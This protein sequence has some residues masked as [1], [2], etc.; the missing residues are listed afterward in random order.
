[1]VRNHHNDEERLNTSEP[2]TSASISGSSKDG[3]RHDDRELLERAR[4]GDQSAF[5]ELVERY[6]QKAYGVAFGFCRNREDALDRVQEAFVKAY[7]NITRFEGSSSFYTWFYRILVNVCID[8]IRKE[9]KRK[10]DVGY[11]DGYEHDDKDGAFV[12]TTG[13]IGNA[14]PVKA[15]AN[16]ELGE[17]IQEAM[18]KLSESHR[19]IL[20]LREVEGLSYEELS[21]VLGVPRGTVMSRL[22]HARGKLKALLAGYVRS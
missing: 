6:Q 19:E 17:K 18:G 10:G 14:N 5:R 7:R 16:Q 2:N 21:E 15:L 22:H 3:E 1:M 11:E 4:G 20:V 9:K 13:S 8:F 12:S